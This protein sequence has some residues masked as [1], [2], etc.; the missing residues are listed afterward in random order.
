MKNYEMHR[1]LRSA[2]KVLVHAKRHKTALP[3]HAELARFLR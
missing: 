3:L 1:S 2:P